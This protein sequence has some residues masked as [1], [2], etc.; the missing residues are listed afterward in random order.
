MSGNVWEW[1]TDHFC[2]YNTKNM[3]HQ[4]NQSNDIE[5]V[6][7]GGSFDD[8]ENFASVTSRR[9]NYPNVKLYFIGFRV[10]E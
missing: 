1:C 8:N 2:F 7:R 6:T 5:R 4:K 10:A 9:N 3:E